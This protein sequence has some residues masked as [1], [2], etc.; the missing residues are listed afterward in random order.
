MD[1]YTVVMS[2][3][4]RFLLKTYEGGIALCGRVPT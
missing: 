3:D 1:D 2:L 4:N